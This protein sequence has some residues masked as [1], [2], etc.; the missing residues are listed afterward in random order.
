MP[1]APGEAEL[2]EQLEHALA[3]AR[4]ARLGRDLGVHREVRAARADPAADVDRRRRPP[5]SASAI[6]RTVSRSSAASRRDDRTAR[7]ATARA[8]VAVMPSRTP[9]AHAAREHAITIGACSAERAPAASARAAGAIAPPTT[10]TGAPRSDGSTRVAHW[11]ENCGRWMQAIRMLQ[12]YL[13][14]SDVQYT[15]GGASGTFA[16][17][18][19]PA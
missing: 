5:S 16:L 15:S 11:S 1:I 10:A 17:G 4:A 2:V 19:L 7:R 6:A 9:S 18:F 8:A 12:L 14:W 3:E 13:Y